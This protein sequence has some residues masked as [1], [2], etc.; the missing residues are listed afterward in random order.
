MIAVPGPP[1]P[2]RPSP[3]PRPGPGPAPG[4]APA[5]PGAAPGDPGRTPWGWPEFFVLALTLTP[6][7]LFLPGITP[8]RAATRVA[9]FAYGLVAW[10]V[11]LRRG[12]G[13]AGVKS[14]PARPWLIFCAVWLVCQIGNPGNYSLK[15]AVGQVL[16]YL[17]VMSPAFWAGAAIST[18]RQFGRLMAVLFLCNALSS[19]LGVA[20]VYYPERFNPPVI[21]ALNGVFGGE[22]LK[23]EAA[24]GRK[25]LRPCGLS[26]TPG[27]VAPAGATTA[28]IGLCWALRPVGV[29]RR[30]A[31]LGLAFAG[32]AVIY[33]TQVR[34]SM[35]TLGVC[36]A[37][38]TALW[39]VQGNVRQA[40]TLAG[41]GLGLAA[42]ALA[43]VARTV[44][45]RAVERFGTLLGGDP[46]DLYARSRGGF[47]KEALTE[48]VWDYPLGLG[49]G[50]YGMIHALFLDPSRV[51]LV[52]V[53]VMIQAFVYDGGVPLLVGY[54]G[55]LAAALLDSLRIAL[56]SR[57]RD[58]RF[59]A[60]VVFSQNLSL[61]ANCFSF[62]TFLSVMGP[63]FWLFAAAL[64][65]ADA[66]SRLGDPAAR[67]RPR[68]RPRVRRAWPGGSAPR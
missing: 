45:S 58:L 13:A 14:F 10:G 57:D 38:L 68:P 63:P 37:T 41:G 53:E 46:A 61:V 9:R 50:W 26:D 7:L 19:V 29:L 36:T 66:R 31:S 22:D 5:R 34:A 39:L 20:Q 15:A 65:A 1:F 33:F 59:W 42:G 43:W 48:A 30:L 3:R 49:L 28:L 64:H 56:T 51:S 27:S 16:L 55:A 35:V 60:A 67:P 32:V 6:A 12:G 25:I 4:R 24:D 18:P 40:L 11:F 8:V 47:V 62:A 17:A 2:H 23:Y 21:P 54:G 44:G 52:W